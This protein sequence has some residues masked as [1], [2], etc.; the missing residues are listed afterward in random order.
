MYF[1]VFLSMFASCC[2]WMCVDSTDDEE[3]GEGEQR[4]QSYTNSAFSS[5][6]SPPPPEHT[7]KACGGRFD[8]PAKKVTPHRLQC[9]L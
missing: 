5:Q 2:N 6:P 3:S 1:C 8:T 9:D 4:H 7:C